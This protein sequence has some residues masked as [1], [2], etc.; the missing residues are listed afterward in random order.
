VKV[1]KKNCHFILGMHNDVKVPFH[2][3]KFLLYQ[4]LMSGKLSHLITKIQE[5]DFTI[6]TTNTIKGHDL[7]LHLAQHVELGCITKNDVF[8]SL[9]SMFLIEYEN[10]DMEDHP[11]YS[12]YHLLFAT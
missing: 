7:A 5:C 8:V 10:V 4:T 12:G 2:N 6:T 1:I 3:V 9:S 11:W